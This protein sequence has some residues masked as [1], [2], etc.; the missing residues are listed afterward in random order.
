[1]IA[2]P[3]TKAEAA[4]MLRRAKRVHTVRW[5]DL[6]KRHVRPLAVLRATEHPA[7]PSHRHEFW[8]VVV[9][10]RGSGQMRFGTSKLPI[11]VGDV[12]VIAH[13]QTHAYEETRGLDVFN[14]VFD[15]EYLGTVHPLLEDWLSRDALFAV[16]PHWKST[17]V[18]GECLHLG[19]AD[20]A[21]LNEL[22]QRME[23]ELDKQGEDARVAAFAYF[24]LLLT[25]LRRHSQPWADAG[26]NVPAARVSRALDYID[27]NFAERITL[28][29]L[30]AACHVSR[31]HFFRLFEQAV[32]VAPMEY[33]KKVRL[34]KAAEM[35]LTSESNV[36]EVAFA[37]GF[38]D[39]NYFSSLYHKEFGM[40]PSQ[41]KREG[42]TG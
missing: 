31:R 39:S 19:S 16:G 4:T 2:A 32:G 24:L 12:F 17:D 10:T 25:L 15:A 20:F 21:R 34:Q 13:G 37:C 40:S 30:A 3:T 26:S 7:W 27:K 11:R 28:D 18:A 33:L 23:A 42:R 14:I 22:V 29:E 35:L 8:E 5:R 38:N 9:V 1:M 36:T 6:P 41:F